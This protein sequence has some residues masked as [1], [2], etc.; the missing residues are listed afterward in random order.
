MRSRVASFVLV[1]AIAVGCAS[2]VGDRAP[3]QVT[4][5]PSDDR[6]VELTDAQLARLC[7]DVKTIL[8]PD[9]KTRALCMW[10]ALLE[11]LEQIYDGTFDAARCHAAYDDCHA[12][13]PV[14]DGDDFG[15]CAAFATDAQACGPLLVG[16]FTPCVLAYGKRWVTLGDAAPSACDSPLPAISR[17]SRAPACNAVTAACE[18]LVGEPSLF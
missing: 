6:L 15:D 11:Q 8:G 9:Q 12:N 17:F 10:Q 5:I 3:T 1:A 18:K 16:D 7:I 14:V 13:P 4:S 2:K